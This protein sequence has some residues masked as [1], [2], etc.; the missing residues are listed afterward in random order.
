MHFSPLLRNFFLSFSFALFAP[1]RIPLFDKIVRKKP[2]LECIPVVDKFVAVGMR[3]VFFIFVFTCR[4]E[5]AFSVII[6]GGT[7]FSRVP[8]TP[9]KE[10]SV[11]CFALTPRN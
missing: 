3:N 8:L 1:E 10:A 7:Q 6:V 11:P 4:F 9:C 2:K 5:F